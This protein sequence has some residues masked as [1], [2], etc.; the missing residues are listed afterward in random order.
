M[1]P[2]CQGRT[3]A[4]LLSLCALLLRSITRGRGA[5]PSGNLR[6]KELPT[7]SHLLAAITRLAHHCQSSLIKRDHLALYL[8][9]A[10]PRRKSL[11]NFFPI[12][13]PIKPRQTQTIA[14]RTNSTVK[15]ILML[16]YRFDITQITIVVLKISAILIIII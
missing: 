9:C 14:N 16:K 1:S 4:Y 3:A 11:R 6:D 5:Y 2:T 10:T 15:L 12:F 7:S 13:V 8:G